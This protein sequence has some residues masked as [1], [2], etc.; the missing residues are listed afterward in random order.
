MAESPIS[1]QSINADV[2]E[3]VKIKTLEFV[4]TSL[5][6]EQA[7]KQAETVKKAL[8]KIAELESK[9]ESLTPADDIRYDEEGVEIKSWSK[10][11]VVEKTKA[12]Q[13]LSQ[14]NTALSQA[15]NDNNWTALNKKFS[16][17]AK[18]QG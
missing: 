2:A 3:R 4:V 13:E 12:A 10:K 5:A 15:L 9:V 8:V 7:E 17:G 6:N 16:G 11:R 14:T 1:K 18:Q